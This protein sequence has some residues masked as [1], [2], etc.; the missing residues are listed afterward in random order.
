MFSKFGSVFG[1]TNYSNANF[2]LFQ[3]RITAALHSSILETQSFELP[4]GYSVHI[5]KGRGNVVNDHIN[6]V[7]E[8]IDIPILA[9]ITTAKKGI[10]KVPGR[11]QCSIRNNHHGDN[12]ELTTLFDLGIGFRGAI[13]AILHRMRCGG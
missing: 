1:T 5:S 13:V 8:P 12:D 10:P 6:F 7:S 9:Y 11:L 3:K 4:C 2:A